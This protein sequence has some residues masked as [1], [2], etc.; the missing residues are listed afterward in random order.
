MFIQKYKKLFIFYLIFVFLLNLIFNLV[1]H[2][3]QSQ[4]K[5]IIE[6]IPPNELN[7]SDDL[8]H[9][10]YI[11]S[12]ISRILKLSVVS[13]EL[14]LLSNL[15][16]KSLDMLDNK[17][18]IFEI[19]KSNRLAYKKYIRFERPKI[20]FILN[21]NQNLNYENLENNLR[22]DILSL[23]FRQLDREIQTIRD[24]INNSKFKKRYKFHYKRLDELF[25]EMNDMKENQIRSIF[26]SSIKIKF[27]HEENKID[28]F[29]RLLFFLLSLLIIFV[30]M[31][32]YHKYNLKT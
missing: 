19:L 32:T 22:N 4:T 2:L 23:L 21:N 24:V 16:S 5:L 31:I 11:T 25:K 9:E 27:N 17:Q 14:P 18:D 30:L 3:K 20:T 10:N 7:L 28:N 29:K 1:I 12:R 26:Q 6:F 8:V 13:L 15:H